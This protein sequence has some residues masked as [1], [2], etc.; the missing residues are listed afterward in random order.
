MDYK[1]E[2]INLIEKIQD[3]KVLKYI[4]SFIK[5]FLKGWS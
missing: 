3:E 5:T 2:T 1:K 4:Y